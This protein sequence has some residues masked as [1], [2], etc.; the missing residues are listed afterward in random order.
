MTYTDTFQ[1]PYF[2]VT[3]AEHTEIKETLLKI[4]N[5]DEIPVKMDTN[6]NIYKTDFFESKKA[7]LYYKI[8]MPLID[9]SLRK[10]SGI[11]EYDKLVFDKR[12][13]IWYQQYNKL[14]YHSWHHHGDA[15]WS[16]V[17]YVELSEDSP[18]TQFKDCITSKYISPN[19]KEGDILIFPGWMLHRSPP[20]LSKKRKTIISCN[21]HYYG[22]HSVKV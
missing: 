17:Y 1:I 12:S 5:E 22:N 13:N 20:N 7:R 14:D 9:K 18:G 2:I 16:I 8:I 19:V 15:R 6:Q 3:L 21:F 10:F 4:I 11:I